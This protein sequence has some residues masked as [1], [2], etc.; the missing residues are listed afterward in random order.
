ALDKL[1]EWQKQRETME[2][3]AIEAMLSDSFTADTMKQMES[4]YAKLN[5]DSA[6]DIA[7]TAG[8]PDLNAPGNSM[9][10][11]LSNGG[12][13][14]DLSELTGGEGIDL[15]ELTGGEGTM[16]FSS[17]S[18][19]TPDGAAMSGAV[20]SKAIVMVRGDASDNAMKSTTIQATAIRVVASGDGGP[21]EVSAPAPDAN[22]I[23]GAVAAAN[24]AE[25]ADKIAGTT[26]VMGNNED[27]PMPAMLGGGGVKPLSRQD[28]EALRTRLAV[29]EA[30]RAVWETLAA[31]LLQASAEWMKTSAE[32]DMM[33]KPDQSPEQ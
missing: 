26:A 9:T 1:D 30:Q 22:A 17:I 24:A 32:G 18:T 11:D 2:E 21:I 20:A 25:L 3:A 31:D 8:M 6:S 16:V 23:T 7:A 14:I 28:I 12:E 27:M 4:Q 15:S 33:P 19:D 29:Q 10:I 13:G 5:S